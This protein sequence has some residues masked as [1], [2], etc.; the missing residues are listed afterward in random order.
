[1]KTI[2]IGRDDQCNIVL[3]DKSS[4]ISRRHAVVTIDNMGKM[5]I[6]DYSA[7]GTYING[8]KISSNV[9]VPV[10]R[11]DTVS[12]AHVADLDWRLVP[13]VKGK[14]TT[15]I[16]IL[17][18]AIVIVGV[19]LGIVLSKSDQPDQ[20]DPLPQE[21]LLV[22][23]TSNKPA[24]VEPKKPV[25]EVKPEQPKKEDKKEAKPKKENK[26]S[27]SEKPAQQEEIQTV[28]PIIL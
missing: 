20:P 22:D 8:I 4:V 1:M 13:N 18:A 25:E 10:T 9:P 17:A 24:I 2:S 14:L 26:N 21:P 7:N 3:I 16:S 6:T 15:I 11:K 12:F 19:V 23:T 28:D 27:N 5:T